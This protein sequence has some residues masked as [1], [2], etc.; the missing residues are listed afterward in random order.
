MR[1][2]HLAPS[3]GIYNPAGNN[4]RSQIENFLSDNALFDDGLARW[5]AYKCFLRDVLMSTIKGSKTDTRAHE[6]QLT[7]HARR[8]EEEYISTPT[9]ASKAS[10]PTAQNAL[11]KVINIKAEKKCLFSEVTFNVEGEQT[12]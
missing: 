2:E 4:I 7:Q 11:T 6:K 10:R 5:D 12:S 1:S 9:E 8:L 3:T